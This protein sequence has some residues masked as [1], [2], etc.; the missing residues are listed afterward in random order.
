LNGLL[1]N[2]FPQKNKSVK[3][4]TDMSSPKINR[5]KRKELDCDL[6]TKTYMELE[7]ENEALQGKV[8]SL[9]EEIELLKAKLKADECDDDV[10]DDDEKEDPV[11]NPNDPWMNK[12]NELREYRIIHEDSKVL[13]YKREVLM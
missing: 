5:K 8:V 3:M 13:S 1:R 6:P 4:S 9:K 11:T 7:A 2:H 12:F 10:S